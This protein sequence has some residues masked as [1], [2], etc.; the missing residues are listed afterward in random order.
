M[1]PTNP[2]AVH[3]SLGDKLPTFPLASLRSVFFFL[4]Y[5]F[6]KVFS[7]LSEP[8]EPSSMVRPSRLSSPCFSFSQHPTYNPD[9]GCHFVTLLC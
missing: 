5:S 6:W 2:H 1:Y 9:N 7:H 3:F 4:K 8:Q